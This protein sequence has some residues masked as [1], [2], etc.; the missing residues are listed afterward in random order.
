MRAVSRT[1]QMEID[2]TIDRLLRE[3][4]VEILPL[5]PTDRNGWIATVLDS[6][7]M[8]KHPPQTDLFGGMNGG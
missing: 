6:L 8:P 7:G 5:E 1:F 2:Q 3:F 4:E